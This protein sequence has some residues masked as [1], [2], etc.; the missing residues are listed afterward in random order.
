MSILQMANLLDIA[1]IF[2]ATNSV[3]WYFL[4]VC[5]AAD[6]KPETSV[7]WDLQ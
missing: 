5:K 3:T 7:R 2:Y 6:S 1:P 4:D